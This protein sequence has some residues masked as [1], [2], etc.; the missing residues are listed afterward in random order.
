MYGM[1]EESQELQFDMTQPME[2][3]FRGR[4]NGDHENPSYF[5]KLTEVKHF[6]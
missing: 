6:R 3:F 2:G 4:G 5:V 1:C